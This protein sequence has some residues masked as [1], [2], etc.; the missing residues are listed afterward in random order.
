[1]V[2]K[3]VQEKIKDV[4]QTDMKRRQ[5]F[6]LFFLVALRNIQFC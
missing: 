4:E 6:L 3:I 2:H 1:M 5:L